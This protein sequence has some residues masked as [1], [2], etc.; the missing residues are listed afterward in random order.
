MS[1]DH[2]VD[3]RRGFTI[4][5]VWW[6]LLFDDLNEQIVHLDQLR[7]VNGANRD[8]ITSRGA[9]MRTISTLNNLYDEES[10]EDDDRIREKRRMLIGIAASRGWRFEQGGRSLVRI[11]PSDA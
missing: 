6:Q 10:D 1:D 9:L 11:E 4:L 2:S 3:F 8:R 7:K 5:N